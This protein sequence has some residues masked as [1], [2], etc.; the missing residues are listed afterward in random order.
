MFNKDRLPDKLLHVASSTP[1]LDCVDLIDAMTSGNVAQIT[2][3]N[4]RDALD[5]LRLVDDDHERVQ[6]KALIWSR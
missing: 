2:L 1:A 4:G 6:M 5:M 3:D